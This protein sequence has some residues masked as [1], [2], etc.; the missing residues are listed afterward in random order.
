MILQM[1]GFDRGPLTWYV[2]VLT[3][4]ICHRTT[5]VISTEGLG[6]QGGGSGSL[7]LIHLRNPHASQVGQTLEPKEAEIISCSQAA[8]IYRFPYLGI[9]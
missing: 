2:C 5:P 4:R 8:N 9:A 6:L 7:S 1:S 3:A